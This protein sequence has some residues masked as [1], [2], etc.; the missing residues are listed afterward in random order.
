MEITP[1]MATV[2]MA[3]DDP[4]DRLLIMDA[5][6]ETRLPNNLHFVEDGQVLMDYLHNRNQYQA[7]EA[8]PRPS[9]ILLDLNMPEKD[10]RQ[11]LVEIKSDP[12][13]RKIPVVVLSTSSD[14]QDILESYAVGASSY[15]AKPVSFEKLVDM[16]KTL[17]TYWLEMVELPV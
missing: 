1:K 9:L 14:R 10:G 5:F 17:V 15:I 11:A 12:N 4:D 3:E 6:R 8:A 13:L 7:V 16:I 2:L